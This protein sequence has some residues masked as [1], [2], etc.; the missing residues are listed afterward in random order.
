M[1][2]DLHKAY[3]KALRLLARRDHSKKELLTK[4]KRFFDAEICQ[5]TLEKLEE[6]KWLKPEQELAEFWTKSLN[7]RNKGQLYIQKFLQGKGLPNLAADDEIELEKCRQILQTKFRRN[8]ESSGKLS[9]EERAKAMRLL[10]NRGFTREVIGR[11][12]NENK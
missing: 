7:Q 9:F 12:L 11:V 2:N 1:Q 3:N 6:K 10:T 8:F 4:L 5:K